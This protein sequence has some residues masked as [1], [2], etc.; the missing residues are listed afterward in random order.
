MSCLY[1]SLYFVDI[2]I[3]IN[4]LKTMKIYNCKVVAFFCIFI[5]LL[6]QVINQQSATWPKSQLNELVIITSPIVSLIGQYK[7]VVICV[8][9][10]LSIIIDQG[11]EIFNQIGDCYMMIV[12]WSGIFSH[13]KQ[14]DHKVVRDLTLKQIVTLF[15]ILPQF[16][17]GPSFNEYSNTEPSL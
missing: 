8:I 5:L 1:L 15:V 14:K 7:C 10:A 3:N 6:K 13:L 2:Y 17:G 16:Q 12:Q 4:I 9:Q 11:R